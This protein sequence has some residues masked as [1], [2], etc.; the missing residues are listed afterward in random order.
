MT[1][2]LDIWHVLSSRLCYSVTAGQWSFV[3]RKWSWK[4]G[5]GTVEE[6]HTW[7]GNWI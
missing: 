3:G 5:F 6:N 1:F 4:T 7:I 2:N